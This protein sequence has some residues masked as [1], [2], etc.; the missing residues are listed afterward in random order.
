MRAAAKG[1]SHEAKLVMRV[2]VYMHTNRQEQ[3][4]GI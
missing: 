2:S 4:G 3:D 1:V